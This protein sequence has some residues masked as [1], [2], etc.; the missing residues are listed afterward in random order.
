MKRAILIVFVAALAAM[1]AVVLADDQTSLIF[2]GDSYAAGQNAAISLPVSR[3]AFAAGYN[4]TLAAPVTGN[5]HLAGYSVSVGAD[6]GGDL[7]AAGFSVNVT[8]SVKGS[9]SAMGNSVN[10]TAAAPIPGNAR[11]AAQSV[12]VNSAVDGSIL[13]A[14]STMTLNA[15]IKGDFNFYGETLIFGPNAK[16][17]GRVLIQAPKEI[18]VPAS[19]A[20]AD[21]VTFQ[22]L[23]VPDYMGEA[24]KTAGTFMNGFWPL[25]WATVLWWLLLFA[26]GAIGIALLPKVVAGLETAAA[27][28]PFRRIGL[29]LLGF[30]SVLGLVPV[31]AMTVVGIVLLPFVAVFVVLACSVAYLTGAYLVTNRIAGAFLAV[32]SN[33]KRLGVLAVALVAAG[34]LTMVP[35][36]GWLITLLLL[37]FGFGAM[38]VITMARWS[39]GDRAPLGAPPVAAVG[40]V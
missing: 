6:V 16:V 4:V 36:L 29:G 21:R 23:V 17:D 34:L 31:V 18:A 1:P 32:D 22:Q 26:V 38:A 11:L 15:P 14:A 40:G 35:F 25:V 24:G 8:S 3:D 9:V 37:T 5:A 30:A 39:A 28:H 7:Y 13:A 12:V 10:L 27:R 20:A 33:A 19:V 2:G